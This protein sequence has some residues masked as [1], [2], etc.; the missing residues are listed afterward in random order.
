MSNCRNGKPPGG[1]SLLPESNNWRMEAPTACV[2]EG[3]PRKH[4]GCVMEKKQ[5]RFDK[6]DQNIVRVLA[7]YE[8]LRLLDLWYELGEDS[9]FND[10]VSK[11]ELSD[12]MEAL[13]ERGGVESVRSG[14]GEIRWALKDGQV[15]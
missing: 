4:G 10:R 1:A 14:E 15:R 2:A 7:L 5:N 11:E 12:R 6:V 9:A 13:A 3:G 8:S